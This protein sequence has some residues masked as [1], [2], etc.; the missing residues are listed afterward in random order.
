MAS[1]DAKEGV[2]E[3][4]LEPIGCGS[5]PRFV[6]LMFDNLL[7]ILIALGVATALADAEGPLRTGLAVCAYF[8]Y[9]FVLEGAFGRTL[10]KLGLGLVV[11]R[12]DGTRAGWSE[13]AK[14]TLLRSVE[15]NPFLFGALPGALAVV[16]SKR[17]QRLGDRW[18]KTVV[19]LVSPG[20]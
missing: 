9:F 6:A 16:F 10:G 11:R 7:A 8:A 5:S 4:E 12:L 20:T 2:E 13:A 15:V 17:K 14:R 3:A 19:V 1:T 18:A